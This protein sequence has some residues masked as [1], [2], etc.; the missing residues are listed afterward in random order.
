VLCQ[1][2]EPRTWDAFRLTALDRLSGAEPAAHLG[3]QIDVVFKPKSNVK[4]RLQEAIRQLE[5]P[6]SV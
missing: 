1:Q 3:M 5:R 4:K 6:E 2:V